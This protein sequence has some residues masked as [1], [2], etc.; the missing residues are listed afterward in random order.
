[1]FNFSGKNVPTVKVE[2]VLPLY[3]TMQKAITDEL[4]A[5]VHGIYRGGLGV[6]LAQ[7]AFGGD[8]GLEIILKRF[9]QKILIEMI[10]YYFQNQPVEEGLHK[11]LD[12]EGAIMTD[13]GA[14]QI[15]VYGDVETTPKEIVEYQEQI[16]TDIATI[17]DW[18]TGMKVTREYAEHTVK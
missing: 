14:Y 8:L 18:P 10:N 12:F 17:L 11:F 9:P 15:L 16:G 4:M 13:S 3:D 1:M 6:H 7:V 5:S 2:E